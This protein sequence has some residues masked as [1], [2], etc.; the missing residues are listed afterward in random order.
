MANQGCINEGFDTRKLGWLICPLQRLLSWKSDKPPSWIVKRLCGK[1]FIIQHVSFGIAWPLYI[2]W[3]PK[4]NNQF[5]L[6]RFGWRY[7]VNWKGYIFPT[8]AW[9]NGLE[10]PMVKGY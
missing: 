1:L 6:R 8:G 10:K 4:Q 2:V 9:K 3:Q 5:G 7:D